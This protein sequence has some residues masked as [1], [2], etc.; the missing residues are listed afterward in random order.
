[1]T[2]TDSE[3]KRD[4]AEHAFGLRAVAVFEA[5]KGLAVLVA[6]SGLLL[7]VHRDAQRLAERVVMHLHL[8]PASRYPRIFL[9]LAGKSSPGR[10]RV[11]ALGALLYAVLRFA[12]AVG[13]W[14]ARR[15]A[16]WFGVATG[17]MYVP[18]EVVA[19]A[20]RPSLEPVAALLLSLGIVFFLSVRLR[21]ERGSGK[22]SRL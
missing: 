12:E 10:L 13:L 15:W 5:A 17:L 8:N 19:I 7:L 18:F 2:G 3:A 20:R 11:L 9:E 14:H 16:E 21:H 1:M 6:G 22:H 4:A